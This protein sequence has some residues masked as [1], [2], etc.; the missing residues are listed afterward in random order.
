M[1]NNLLTP[2]AITRESARVLENNLVFSK[3]VNREYSDEF[4][5]RGA[6]IGATI[7]ARIPPQYLG[8]TG[9]ALAVEDAVETF[10]PLTLTT[11]FGVDIS[12]TSQ[13]MTLSIDDFSDRFI[14]PAMAAVANKVDFD[15]LTM[16]KNFTWNEVGT[17]G[18]VPNSSLTYLQ[19]RAKLLD[20]ACPVDDQMVAVLS[21]TAE[22]TI[23]DA[24]KGLFQQADKIG[25]QYSLGTM[26]RALGMKFNM[27]QNTQVHTVGPFG[28]APT[29]T[30]AQSASATF[31]GV[32]G[33][34]GANSIAPF[35]LVTGGWTAAAALRVRAGDV[36]TV[37]GVFS[38]NP[39]HRQ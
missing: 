15:G 4:A 18:T 38:V 37:P 12:F 9:A 33:A 21:P 14:K 27:D 24:L 28:G 36:F 22:V 13:D 26:G 34:A 8:R 10:R 29:T 11:Q 5:V 20:M 31:S 39:Q 30:G 7:N 35:P 16:A 17:P 25:E 32:T 3:F 2:V 19:A 1:A 23:V 6:K